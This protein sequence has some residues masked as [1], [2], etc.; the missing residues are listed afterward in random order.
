VTRQARCAPAA[1][2]SDLGYWNEP[3]RTAEAID[4]ARWMHTGDLAVL[5]PGRYLNI[6]GRIKA[7]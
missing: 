6:V 7:W 3:E 5:G 1:I 4:A 2:G